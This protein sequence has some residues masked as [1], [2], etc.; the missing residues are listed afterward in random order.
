M[1]C[2]SLF[3]TRLSSLIS[4]LFSSVIFSISTC[5][6]ISNR[7]CTFSIISSDSRIHCLPD[8]HYARN[9]TRLRKSSFTGMDRNIPWFDDFLKMFKQN[10]TLLKYGC[11]KMDYLNEQI[12]SVCNQHFSEQNIKLLRR[13]ATLLQTATAS[14]EYIATSNVDLGILQIVSGSNAQFGLSLIRIRENRR[15]GNAR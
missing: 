6:L 7:T 1:K 5:H 15:R 13:N 3:S 11:F 14:Q 8:T 2:C 9:N 4:E 12:G 10:Q